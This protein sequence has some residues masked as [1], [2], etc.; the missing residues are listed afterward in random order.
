MKENLVRLVILAALC[1]SF[2]N[3]AFGEDEMPVAVAVDLSDV[4]FCPVDSA[5]AVSFRDGMA[6]WEFRV[7]DKKIYW[8]FFTE[9]KL[10]QISA[11]NKVFVSSSSEITPSTGNIYHGTSLIFEQADVVEV[12]FFVWPVQFFPTGINFRAPDGKIRHFG[13][14]PFGPRLLIEMFFRDFKPFN[15]RK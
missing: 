6:K 11:R 14:V 2:S 12:V 10:K 8:A 5:I 13:K 7:R 3:T 15:E 4:V 1:V 9:E